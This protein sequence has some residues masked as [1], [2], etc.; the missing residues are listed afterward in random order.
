[1]SFQA[2]YTELEVLFMTYT[3]GMNDEDAV[4]DEKEVRDN[5]VENAISIKIRLR[6]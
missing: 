2:A 5:L 3:Q 4:E 1:M 6:L